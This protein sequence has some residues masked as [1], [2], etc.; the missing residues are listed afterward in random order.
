M[1][2]T[3]PDWLC[4]LLITAR[5]PGYDRTVVRAEAVPAIWLRNRPVY[6]PPRNQ[7]VRPAGTLTVRAKTAVMLAGLA[8]VPDPV[9][10]GDTN[11]SPATGTG[12]VGAGAGGGVDPPPVGGGV[13]PV[14][15]GVV[16]T[17][18]VGEK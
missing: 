7:T 4:G 5:S 2:N 16:V 1:I 15:G 8:R 18:P 10:V 9:P 11:T 14:G 6:V 12:E 17:A 3:S 13:V